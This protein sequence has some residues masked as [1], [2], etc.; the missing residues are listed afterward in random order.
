MKNKFNI[1]SYQLVCIS[2]NLQDLMFGKIKNKDIIIYFN[3]LILWC[4]WK[5]NVLY[6]KK[7]KSNAFVGKK[8]KTIF[9]FLFTF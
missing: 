8:Y 6:I 2:S 3:R 9:H 5:F 1:V 4:D 7:T